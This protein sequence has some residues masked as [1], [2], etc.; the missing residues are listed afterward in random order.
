M[1]LYP[2]LYM[3]PVEA[4]PGSGPSASAKFPPIAAGSL[5]KPLTLCLD[6]DGR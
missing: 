3:S 6:E 5:S 4:D 2:L 1:G